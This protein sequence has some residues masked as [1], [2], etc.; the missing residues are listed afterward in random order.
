[1]ENETNLLRFFGDNPFTR[2]LDVFID[3][4]GSA[5]SK[6]EVQEL[7]GISKGA[8]FNHWQKL[9]ELNLVQVTRAFGNTKLFTLNR[10]SPLV[11]ELLKLEARMIEETSPKK[12]KAATMVL[13]N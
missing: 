11:K 1:M 6:K 5:Y 8:L 13:R 12:E 9:E 2:M 7:A 10:K 3:N 4:I